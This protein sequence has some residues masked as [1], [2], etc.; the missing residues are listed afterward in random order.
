M[1][2]NRP[3]HAGALIQRFRSLHV[4]ATAE[5]AFMLRRIGNAGS[6]ATD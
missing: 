2:D 3:M 6:Q 4:S 1:R 5:Q